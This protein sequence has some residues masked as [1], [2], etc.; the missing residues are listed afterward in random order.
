MNMTATQR[1]EVLELRRQREA[2]EELQRAIRLIA[3]TKA[4]PSIPGKVFVPPD[5]VQAAA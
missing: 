2:E 5:L 4:N 1:D 3:Y